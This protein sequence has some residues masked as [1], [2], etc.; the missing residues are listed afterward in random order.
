MHEQPY[1][2]VGDYF[3]ELSFY[4]DRKFLSSPCGDANQF[5]AKT[6]PEWII[7]SGKSPRDCVSDEQLKAFPFQIKLGNQFLLGRKVAA[8]SVV[9][10]TPLYRELKAPI[11]GVSSSLPQDLPFRY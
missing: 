8:S 5:M 7:T 9:D 1:G 10:L 3:V 11:D 6:L 4:A 2:S